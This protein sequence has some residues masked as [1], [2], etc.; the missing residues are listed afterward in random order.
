M[1]TSLSP[2]HRFLS[3]IDSSIT[4]R[5]IVFLRLWWSYSLTQFKNLFICSII[6][7][8]QRMK[9]NGLTTDDPLRKRPMIKTYSFT[10]D[11]EEKLSRENSLSNP[12]N[13]QPM[14]EQ[15]F[16]RRKILPPENPLK[17]NHRFF[18]SMKKI[19]VF[20]RR[21]FRRQRWKKILHLDGFGEN[22]FYYF[23]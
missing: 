10:T 5:I 1:M 12:T 22:S 2:R 8:E 19:F 13:D 16:K 18:S 23:Y 11:D 15:K 9:S 3:R 6:G 17:V 14:E 4:V 20:F 21:K 7:E